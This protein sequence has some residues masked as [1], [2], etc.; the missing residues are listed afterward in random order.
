[1]SMDSQDLFQILVREH[2]D[3][4]TVFLRC[5]VRDPSVVDDLFQET[6]LTAWRNLHRFDKTRPFGPW[7]RGIAAKLI[8]AHRRKSARSM[9]LC[10][11]DILEHL[12]ARH[13]ALAQSPGDTLDEKLDGLRDCLEQLP[14][15]YRLAVELRY[16]E[17]LHGARLA[18]RLD[19]S[20]EATKKRLQRGR[21][22]LLD[23]LRRKLTLAGVMS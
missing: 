3:M 2:A 7:L 12:E 10:D 21:I 1:M 5:A 11:A 19:I 17:G 9:L 4:L 6:M 18:E 20:G 13:A 8:L 16:R 14:E 15:T 23:C 22:R